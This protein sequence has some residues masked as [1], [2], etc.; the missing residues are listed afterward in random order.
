ME[1]IQWRDFILRFLKLNA[2]ANIFLAKIVASFNAV[3]IFLRTLQSISEISRKSRKWSK[4]LVCQR[5]SPQPKTEYS[6]F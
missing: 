1:I 6:K 5:R 2:G 3:S 4:F